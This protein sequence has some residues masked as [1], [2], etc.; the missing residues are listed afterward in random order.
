MAGLP[1]LRLPAGAPSNYRVRKE[2]KAEGLA[3]IEAISRALGIIESPTI[4]MQLDALLKVMS[5]RTLKSRGRIGS[6]IEKSDIQI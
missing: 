6:I 5:D 2:T 4:Q 3:T 1:K